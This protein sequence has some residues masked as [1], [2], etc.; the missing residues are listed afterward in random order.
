MGRRTLTKRI[1]RTAFTL[2]KSLLKK[3]NFLVGKYTEWAEIVAG[4]EINEKMKCC[5]TGEFCQCNAARDTLVKTY[6]ACSP[7]R[8]DRFKGE[9][10]SFK[11]F[12]QMS[13]LDWQVKDI[14]NWPLLL[15]GIFVM[16]YIGMSLGRWNLYGFKYE[17]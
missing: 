10:A 14:R 16:F 12:M 6:I 15:V 2:K 3:T 17:K 7:H 9:Y 8:I 5:Q 1:A 13:P 4:P 11:E